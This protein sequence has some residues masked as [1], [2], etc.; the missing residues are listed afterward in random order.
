MD[1]N[2]KPYRKVLQFLKEDCEVIKDRNS[3]TNASCDA[4]M[5]SFSNNGT[6]KKN[7]KK[8]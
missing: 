8:Q 6:Y 7:K 4:T 3:L 1:P 2:F 5:T